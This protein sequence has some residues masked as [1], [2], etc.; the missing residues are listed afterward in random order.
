MPT[1]TPPLPKEVHAVSVDDTLAA[2]DAAVGCQ[3]CG[4]PLDGSVSADFDT[5]ECQT[6]WHGARTSRLPGGE[7]VRV[8]LWTDS[9]TGMSELIMTRGES[10]ARAYEQL[11]ARQRQN[12]GVV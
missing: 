1:V 2:I 5:E 8:Y 6:A 9:A 12:R 11:V 3:Q 10:I 7:P 4:R